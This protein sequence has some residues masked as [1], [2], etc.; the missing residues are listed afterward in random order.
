MNNAPMC[1]L[2]EPG[3]PTLRPPTVGTHS[4][5]LTKTSG[6]FHNP[7]SKA[8]IRIEMSPGVTFLGHVIARIILFMWGSSQV[9]CSHYNIFTQR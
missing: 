1:E 7:D 2:N 5:S 9:H 3:T 6:N 8:S 4:Y